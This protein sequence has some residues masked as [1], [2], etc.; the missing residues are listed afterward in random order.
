LRG[1]RLQAEVEHALRQA[2]AK[3]VQEGKEVRRNDY[4]S[5]DLLALL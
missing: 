4:V 3:A 5:P 1:F 2:L